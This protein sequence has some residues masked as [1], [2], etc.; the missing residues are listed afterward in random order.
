MQA[1]VVVLAET[2][3][4]VVMVVGLELEAM[5]V[6][7]G[8]ALLVALQVQTVLEALVEEEATL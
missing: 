1:M 2:E 4:L 8:T 5:Q 6:K 7:A 3:R